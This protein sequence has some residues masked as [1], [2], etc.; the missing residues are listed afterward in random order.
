M[1]LS[2]TRP[3]MVV[4]LKYFRQ[5][6]ASQLLDNLNKWQGRHSW[7]FKKQMESMRSVHRVTRILFEVPMV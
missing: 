5:L 4:A 1:L 6:V 3:M 2:L 7:Q